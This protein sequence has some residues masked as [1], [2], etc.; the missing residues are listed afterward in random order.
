MLSSVHYEKAT[1]PFPVG[2]Q[3]AWSPIYLSAATEQVSAS[4]GGPGPLSWDHLE[5]H[6]HNAGARVHGARPKNLRF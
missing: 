5:T 2:C 1:F 4:G 3:K 6:V